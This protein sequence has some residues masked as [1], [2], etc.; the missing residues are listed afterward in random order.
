MNGGGVATTLAREFTAPGPVVGSPRFLLP[1][2]SG[3]RLP[4]L[5]SPLMMPTS[6]SPD[7]VVLDGGWAAEPADLWVQ[8]VSKLRPLHEPLWRELGIREGILATTCRVRR[9]RGES[10]LLHQLVPFWSPKTN[11]FVFPWGEA[12]V[13]LEDAAVLAGLPLA[14]SPVREHLSDQLQMGDERAL[15]ATRRGLLVLDQSNSAAG[16]IEHFLHRRHQHDDDETLEHGAFLSMWLSHFVLPSPPPFGAVDV[17]PHEEMIPIAARLARGQ[18]VALAPAALAGIYSDLSALKGHLAWSAN[19]KRTGAAAPSISAPTM[20][21]LKLWVWERFPE[22]RPATAASLIPV[23]AAAGNDDDVPR[24]VLWHDVV[25]EALEPSYVRAVLAAPKKFEW[26]PYGNRALKSFARCLRP[27]ELVGMDCVE[28][29]SPH[30]VARQLGFDQDVPGIV[31]RLNSESWEKAWATYD[32][33]AGC[34][35][36]AVPSDKPGVTDE[37]VQWWKPYSLSCA[38]ALVSERDNKAKAC[39]EILGGENENKWGNGDTTVASNKVFDPLF[40]HSANK[41]SKRGSGNRESSSSR[42][43]E[44]NTGLGSSIEAV[45]TNTLYYLSVF[46]RPKEAWA[47]EANRTDAGQ[48]YCNP[49]RAVGTIDMIQKASEM[50][51]AEK[52]ELW[53]KIQKLA[54]EIREEEEAE[55][56]KK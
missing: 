55:A 6:I 22:L 32:I 12:T 9:R 35:E 38:A 43:A 7:L 26:R 20:H 27:C 28:Q 40:G 51:Q 46:D 5:P 2:A 19:N 24:A 39:E 34:Y 8:W 21:I 45:C 47:K 23:P 18:G 3:S 33:G 50:R 1:R 44:G 49:K 41:A 16:W 53:K 29:H 52:A 15:M 10:A 37:Y 25:G 31:T 42:L 36:F 14:G 54:K 13:T 30:R 17:V 11:T 56:L 4:P 48:G